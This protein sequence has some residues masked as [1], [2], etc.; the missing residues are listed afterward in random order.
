M[1]RSDAIDHV[2]DAW[3]RVILLA[4]ANGPRVEVE[5]AEANAMQVDPW[6]ER[7]ENGGLFDE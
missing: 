7:Q 6:F 4:A 2:L 5:H 1:T 3:L